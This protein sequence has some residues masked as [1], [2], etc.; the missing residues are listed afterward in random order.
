V[1]Q[2]DIFPTVMNYLHYNKPY[3]A[4]GND[5]LKQ[6]ADHFV[7]N[8]I[9][10]DYQII[11]GDYVM[12]SRDDKPI[13]LFNYRKDIFLKQNLLESEPEQVEKMEKHLKAFIQQYNQHMI[14]NSLT[15]SVHQVH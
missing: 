14:D 15:V 7:I 4:F 11:M 1:Q 10:D 5:M 13:K 2:I 8:T 9:D 3:F 6:D 12:L